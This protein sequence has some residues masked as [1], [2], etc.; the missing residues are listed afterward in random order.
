[1]STALRAK[2][3]EAVRLG[4]DDVPEILDLIALTRA[5][6]LPAPHGRTRRLP[7]YPAPRQADRAGGR[8]AATARLDG[9][10]RGLHSRT[11]A[12]R[13]WPR[14]WS[15]R[16]RPASGSAENT[17][18]LHASATNTGAIRL[19]ESIGFT[20]RRRS[21]FLLVRTPGARQGT[22]SDPGGPLC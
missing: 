3:T 20:L 5:G 19:Y 22:D 16:S 12:A 18:F 21:E 8:T 7:R 9:D 1:M 2:T 10:Q 6:A 4:P 14:D 11:T 15:A 13:A 17:P